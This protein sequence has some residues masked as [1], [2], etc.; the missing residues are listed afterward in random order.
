MVLKRTLPLGAGAAYT[1]AAVEDA[2]SAEGGGVPWV[3][4][5]V[6]FF[7][8]DCTSDCNQFWYFAEQ[9]ESVW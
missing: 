9:T 8:N 5:M 7:C 4:G 2:V 1:T 6:G 3:F